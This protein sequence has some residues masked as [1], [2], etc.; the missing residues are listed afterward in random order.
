MYESSSTYAARR[1]GP[2]AWPINK[3]EWKNSGGKNAV[4]GGRNKSPGK[5]E[6]D[7][8]QRETRRKDRERDRDQ[9]KT[10]WEDGITT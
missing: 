3:E 10:Q 4:R 7:Q 6:C 1:Q 8:G 5:G 2:A 9:W